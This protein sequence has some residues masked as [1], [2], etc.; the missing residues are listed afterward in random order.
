[1][2]AP[3]PL[4]QLRSPVVVEV[5]G[6]R[7]YKPGSGPPLQPITL[8]P[9]RDSTAYIV[10]KF[11]APIG[12]LP[13]AEGQ[14]RM[15]YL[16]RWRDLPGASAT[17]SATKVLDYV[18]PAELEE[19]EYNELLLREEEE[20]RR[21]T[22]EKTRT[23]RT[24]KQPARPRGR[25]PKARVK[26][27]PI[28]TPELSESEEALIAQKKASG[29]S[30]STPRKRTLR[31]L[32]DDAPIV[33]ET[34]DD[35][36][37]DDAAIARQ[38]E[39]EPAVVSLR[40][41]GDLDAMDLDEPLDYQ[42]IR[43]GPVKTLIED[44]SRSSS[45][46]P[47]PAAPPTSM[48]EKGNSSDPKTKRVKSSPPA[49]P[50]L[51]STASQRKRKPPKETRPSLPKMPA[52]RAPSSSIPLSSSPATPTRIHPMFA[53]KFRGGQSTGSSSTY[54]H[55]APLG[56]KSTQAST[57]ATPGREPKVHPALSQQKKPLVHPYKM[58]PASSRSTT[59]GNGTSGQLT[60]SHGFT[61]A[62][63]SIS[64][65]PLPPTPSPKP[66]ASQSK[67]KT[68]KEK[69]II[70]EPEEQHWEVKRLLDDR[71]RYNARNKL[72]HEYQ[73][74][75]AGDWPPDQNPTWEP[76]KNISKVLIKE[77]HDQRR[78][79]NVAEA[80]AGDLAHEEDEPEASSEDR[81]KEEDDETDEEIGDD[82]LVVTEEKQGSSSA[83]SEK[84]S[85]LLSIGLTAS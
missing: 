8:V 49:A 11:V 27:E 75:W 1:M 41:C 30:L 16:I 47:E 5:E 58:T 42:R 76:K 39:S 70:P 60:P 51:T 43:G 35:D 57:Q 53:K 84:P 14:R 61:P 64:S 56:Q 66:P 18:S 21:R 29:P 4:E 48:R 71:R 23:V 34:G 10:N 40:E 52:T 50:S 44:S 67:S 37:S 46:L 12:A 2:M 54:L 15:Q 79:S 62:A 77:Y 74:L 32:L 38:L 28:D 17:V 73:V 24:P 13:G 65:A 45:V 72:V 83:I 36:A 78:Y 26:V 19:W 7:R 82:K 9:R 3:G 81:S 33:E 22:G 63:S 6:F 31:E 68:P 20:E 80:F 69:K 55:P 85:T 25:P 59:H